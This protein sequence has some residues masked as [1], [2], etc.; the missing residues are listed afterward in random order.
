MVKQGLLKL[1]LHCFESSHIK[2]TN[3]QVRVKSADVELIAPL[4]TTEETDGKYYLLPN[5]DKLYLEMVGT[6][7]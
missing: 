6:T 3:C 2:D 1:Q 7:E 4:T 5:A